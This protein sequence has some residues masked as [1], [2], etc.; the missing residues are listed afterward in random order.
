MDI[1][2]GMHTHGLVA[3]GETDAYLTDV[4][5][6]ELRL[7]EIAHLAEELGYHSLWF[8]DHIVMKR[9]RDTAHPANQSGRRAYLDR[10]NLIDQAAAIATAAAVTST[11]RVASSV[12]VAPYRHPL[13]VAHQFASLD[14]L[15]GGRL[16]FG[17]SAGWSEGE[18]A[19]LGIPYTERGAIT[20]ECLQIYRL[21]WT[22]PVLDFA[23][24]HFRFADVTMDP[25]PLQQP[26]PP[27]VYGG[28][29]DA[30]ARRAARWCDGLYPLLL[31]PHV[32]PGQ[33][34]HL[35]DVVRR[36]GERAG[37]DLSRFRLYAFTSGRVCDELRGHRPLLTGS[38]AQVVAD[39]E[40]LAAHGYS[41]CT[42]YFD[43]PSGTVGELVETIDRFGR[44]VLPSARSVEVAP[45]F[46]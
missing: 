14:V 21:C 41:H 32:E 22:E 4:P 44:D 35:R 30:G 8:G 7:V 19:A 10:P 28:I 26:H 37:R 5:V 18:F 16:I 31:D 11:I 34:D 13:A 9:A 24:R 39:L 6:E 2:I 33:F 38:P 45:W 42:L 23:G 46:T 27:I 43:V 29:T 3:R 36:E 40:R 20:E 1:G 12:L 15:S 17:V 25:K